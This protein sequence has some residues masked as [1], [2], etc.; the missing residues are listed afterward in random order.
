MCSRL[1]LPRFFF[2]EFRCVLGN[3]NV[4]LIEFHSIRSMVDL[5][6]PISAGSHELQWVV[7]VVVAVAVFYRVFTSRA[8]LKRFTPTNTCP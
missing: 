4:L 3:F 8:A 5:V 1:L 6:W 7:V 2:T